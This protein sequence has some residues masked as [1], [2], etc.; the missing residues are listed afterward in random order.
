MRSGVDLCIELSDHCRLIL[1]VCWD[2]SVAAVATA[3]LNS[4]KP[5][6]KHVPSVP[7]LV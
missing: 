4:L 1:D 6:E 2:A 3:L 5:A 7:R